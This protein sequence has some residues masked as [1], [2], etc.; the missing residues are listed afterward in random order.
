MATTPSRGHTLVWAFA[1][2]AGLV[3]SVA[4]TLGLPS[5]VFAV[6]RLVCSTLAVV[7][8]VGWVGAHPRMTLV[9]GCLCAVAWSD[10]VL[11]AVDLGWRDA[12]AADL[13]LSL[14]AIGLTVTAYVTMATVARPP[15][16][17]GKEAMI[18]WLVLAATTVLVAL[19][20]ASPW[21][22]IVA[23]AFAVVLTLRFIDFMDVAEHTTTNGLQTYRWA[24]VAHVLLASLVGSLVRFAVL[25]ELFML[26]LL[27]PFAFMVRGSAR[28]ATN[29]P[30]LLASIG[31]ACTALVV[32]LEIWASVGWVDA[33]QPRIVAL[34]AFASISAS[35]IRDA[36]WLGWACTLGFALIPLAFRLAPEWLAAIASVAVIGLFIT[37]LFRAES[38]A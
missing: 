20:G 17:P 1:L 19:V 26:V 3:V 38:A 5:S 28:Y 23:L 10:A 35:L 14:C 33:W 25:H 15:C 13:F 8:A 18:A 31:A 24:F 34:V 29:R 11:L 37:L 22:A 30:H 7:G 21:L 2:V 4:H 16:W 27:V 36:R 12:V 6:G 9:A 32:V